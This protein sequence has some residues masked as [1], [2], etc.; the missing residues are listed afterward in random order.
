MK[1]KANRTSFKKGHKGKANRTSFKKGHKGLVGENNPNW[2]GDEAGYFSIHSW[3][4]VHFG[5]PRICE[6]CG[7]KKAKR[8]EWANISKSYKRERTDWLRLCTSCHHKYDDSHRKT[9]ITR[10]KKNAIN[11]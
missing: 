8:Y 3:L 7:N 6:H 2:K 1:R 11:T 10:K 9:W 4:N 5:K